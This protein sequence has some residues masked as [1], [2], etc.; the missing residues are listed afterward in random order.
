MLV[1]VPVPARVL[2][3]GQA[4]ERDGGRGRGP[5][6]PR[7][8]LPRVGVVR[9]AVPRAGP[10]PRLVAGPWAAAYR[11]GVSLSGVTVILRMNRMEH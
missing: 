10:Q 11:H 3:P 6:A 1:R 9:G 5:G 7:A 2:C 4:D 8:E